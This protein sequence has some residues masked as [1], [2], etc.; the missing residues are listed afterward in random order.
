MK[1]ARIAAW[2][3]CGLI[4]A[5]GFRAVAEP[6]RHVSIT[7]GLDCS[8]CHSQSSWSIAHK[9][10]GQ[11]G[12]D[13]SR[14]GFPLTGQHRAGNCVDCH[15]ADRA[16]TR[17]CVGCHADAHQRQLGQACDRC[18]TASSWAAVSGIR[19]HRNTR[20]PLSG[21]HTLAACSECHVRA[22]ENQWRGAPADCYACHAGD[23]QR[24]DIHPLH[25]GVAG[26]VSK[27]ALPK[28]CGSCH[29]TL[30]WSP[31]FAPATFTFRSTGQ[32]L[33]ALQHDAVFPI[34]FG[35]HRRAACGDCH[36]QSEAPRLVVCTSCHAHS[37]PVLIAQ[38]RG[39]APVISGCLHCH[40]GGARR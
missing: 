38:H 5:A 22:S 9:T 20:L 13:H 35:K 2:L 18:H 40:P 39:T 3:A 28:N 23:Y 31:A 24:G 1:H 8:S 27:P 29:R 32:P 7:E 36:A 19:L 6:G 10:A 34:S 17:E 30:S 16:I 11:S 12:F 4:S 37:L 15:R 33:V 26:D 14:T 25:R 21:M